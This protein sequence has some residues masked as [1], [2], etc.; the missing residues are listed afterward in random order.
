MPDETPAEE[1]AAEPV[2]PGVDAAAAGATTPGGYSYTVVDDSTIGHGADAHATSVARGGV[3]PLIAAVAAIVPAVVVG[4][5]IWFVASSGGGGGTGRLRADVT[6]VLNAFSQGQ[7]GA[8]TTR[9]ESELAPGFPSDVPGY[10]GA[11][12]VSSLSQ[13]HGEDVS[14]LVIYDTG[15]SRD[16]VA[17]HFSDALSADP[18]QIDGGQDN[19]ESTL[20]QFSKINDSNVTGIVLVA[21]S[22]DGKTT[23]ILESVQVTSG[24]KGA[25]SP[26]FAAISSRAL[27]DGF[28]GELPPYAG[29]TLIESAHQKKAG[30]RSYAVSYITKDAAPGVLDFYRNE[31]EGAKLT[32][33]TGDASS[34]LLE[35][36]EAIQFAD[37]KQLLVGDVTVGKFADDVS[38]TRIDVTVRVAKK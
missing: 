38:Y 32:V 6:S 2:S 27:P 3:P 29:A 24:A 22:K 17:A 28:P 12:V 13:V 4:A 25:K 33:R 21:E 7:A 5:I 26:T 10:P 35:D 1:P 23:T 9:Y 37:G 19:R 8:I 15:D 36:A 11:K 16:K 30:A 20:H 18:W 14:Y 34:S 31:L